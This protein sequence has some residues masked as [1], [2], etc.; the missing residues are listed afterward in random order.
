MLEESLK[1]RE[2]K[3]SEGPGGSPGPSLLSL[4]YAA[5]YRPGMRTRSSATSAKA[6]NTHTLRNTIS[7]R[8]KP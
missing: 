7:A 1:T 2:Q 6:P 5:A 3:N 4:T 8:K